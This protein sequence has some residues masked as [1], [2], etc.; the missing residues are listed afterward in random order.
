[1]ITVAIS[2]VHQNSAII[3]MLRKI[4]SRSG[5]RLNVIETY[6]FHSSTPPGT[7]FKSYIEELGKNGVDIVIIKVIPEKISK[8]IYNDIGFNIL[9]YDSVKE[10]DDQLLEKDLLKYQ[11]RIFDK[12]RKDDIA[13]VNIDDETVFELLKGSKMCVITYGLASK[14][15]ITASS[16]EEDAH[17]STFIYC[18]QRNITTLE[19][20]NVEPQEF[21]IK[22][23]PSL[24]N[25]I[26]D[27]LA[28]VTVALICDIDAELFKELVL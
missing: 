28:A 26:Y 8:G 3:N 21:P 17:S 27:A 18:L 20:K 13:V 4:F 11:K 1:V 19:N 12:M 6:D 2:G 9:V 23:V 25:S 10:D 22:V 7:T 16:I 24:G 15:T 14:V 5:K